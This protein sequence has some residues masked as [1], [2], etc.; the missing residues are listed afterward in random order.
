MFEDTRQLLDG[1][2]PKTKR[3]FVWGCSDVG[4]MA[5]RAQTQNIFKVRGARHK[6]KTRFRPEL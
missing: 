3:V 4:K 1:G 6:N 5:R 2:V